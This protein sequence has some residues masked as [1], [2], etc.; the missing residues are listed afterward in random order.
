M[1]GWFARVLDAIEK[2][3]PVEHRRAP[4][5]SVS[6][7]HANYSA[8]GGERPYRVADVSLSGAFIESPS[9]WCVGTVM[10]VLFQVDPPHGV[11]PLSTRAVQARVARSTPDGFGVEFIFPDKA[12]RLEFHRFLRLHQALVPKNQNGPGHIQTSSFQ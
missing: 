4:R 7:I 8:G 10:V 6:H 1:R 12:Q 5:K 11:A 3:R 2:N 9:Q